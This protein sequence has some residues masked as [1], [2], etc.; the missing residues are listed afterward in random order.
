ME[1]RTPATG[2]GPT[3]TDVYGMPLR[4]T[5]SEDLYALPFAPT[6][7]RWVKTFV[8]YFACVA[9]CLVSTLRPGNGGQEW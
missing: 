3:L 5:G 8:L 7:E 9:S 1:R 2:K 4:V 6:P